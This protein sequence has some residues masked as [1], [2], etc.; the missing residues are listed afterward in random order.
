MLKRKEAATL[1]GDLVRSK[2]ELRSCDW[3]EIEL[4]LGVC[5]SDAQV[6]CP[7]GD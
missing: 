4:P 2:R 3:V 7:L 5:L 6:N 1:K